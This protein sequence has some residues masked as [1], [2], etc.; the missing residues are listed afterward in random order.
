MMRTS[1][2]GKRS[3]RHRVLFWTLT[4]LTVG[5]LVLPLGGDIYGGLAGAA[6]A[7]QTQPQTNPRANY[8]R[9]VREG[10]AGYSAIPGHAADVL[11]QNGGENWREL[12]NGPVATIGPWVLAGTLALIAAFHL[13]VGPRRPEQ[14]LS[15]DRMPRWSVGER[16]MHW[17]TAILFIV[18]AVTGLSLLFGRAVLIP[19][20]GLNGFAAYAA[21]AKVLHNYLGP[22]FLAGVFLEVAVWMR[23]NL[24][25]RED[26]HW[27]RRLGGMLGGGHAHAGRANGGEKVWFWLIAFVGLLGVGVTGAIMDFPNF[28]QARRTMQIANLLHSSLGILW[29][30]IALGHIYLGTLGTP[31]A[32]EGMVKGHVSKEWMRTHHDRWYEKLAR[33]GQVGSAAEL[34]ERER[35]QAGAPGRQAPG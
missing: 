14:P 23:F 3:G 28:E 34:E 21:V 13:G 6:E 15:G 17:Y 7:A 4:L 9:A 30:T 18:M 16:I 12:R 10:R 24:F 1:A 33:A 2:T 5:G 19:V 35:P 25:G 29:T 20:F 26:W 8:W 22:F 31:G 32:L 11:I 27:L